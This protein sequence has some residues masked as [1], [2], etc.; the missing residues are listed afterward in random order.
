M[1]AVEF[2]QIMMYILGSILLIVLIVL[3][4]KLMSTLNRIDALVDNINGK[5]NQ[6]N[7]LFN[8]ID[9]VTNKVSTITDTFVN[10]ANNL[11]SKIFSK[12]RKEDDID[13]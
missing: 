13:E 9:M 7:G 5:V 12:K 2:L 4:V 8:I 1:G 10:N 6:L 11:I 3:G